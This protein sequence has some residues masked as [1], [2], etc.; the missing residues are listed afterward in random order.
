MSKAKSEPKDANCNKKITESTV[1][2]FFALV[3]GIEKMAIGKQ[4]RIASIGNIE[5]PS[6][7]TK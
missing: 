5:R 1:L 4:K 6:I 3:K 2:V 7:P